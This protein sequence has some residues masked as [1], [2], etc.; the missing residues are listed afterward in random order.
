MSIS[1][2]FVLL[3]GSMSA[4]MALS[5]PEGDPNISFFK[6]AAIICFAAFLWFGMNVWNLWKNRKHNEN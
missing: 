4:W 3:S 2:V 1:T 6:F 5:L